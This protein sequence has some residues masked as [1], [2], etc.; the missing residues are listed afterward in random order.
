MAARNLIFLTPLKLT[1]PEPLG[2][3]RRSKLPPTQRASPASPPGTERVQVYGA[4]D[5]HPRDLRD[6]ADMGAKPLCHT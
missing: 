1:S 3:R 5:T 6:L 2:G 4:E